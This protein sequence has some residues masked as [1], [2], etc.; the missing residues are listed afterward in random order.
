MAAAVPAGAQ[1][2]TTQPD[3][4]PVPVMPQMVLIA[5]AGLLAVV[6]VGL[7]RRRRM[8]GA[9]ALVFVLGVSLA[10]AW[11]SSVLHAQLTR[12]FT[13]PAGETLPIPVTPVVTRGELQGFQ[14][15]DFENTSGVPLR[16]TGIERPDFDACFPDGLEHVLPA[17]TADSSMACAVDDTL[18]D[19]AACRVNVDTICKAL[20]AQ[21]AATPSSLTFEPGATGVLTVTNDASSQVAAANVTVTPPDGSAIIV[22]ATTCGSSLAPG[23]SCELTLT[24]PTAEGP[25]EI[26]IA[27]DN[28]APVPVMVTVAADASTMLSLST[29]RLALAINSPGGDPLLPG[30]PRV[31]TVTNIGSNPASDVQVSSTGFPAGTAITANTCTGTLPA[32][33]SCMLTIT[34]GAVA[35]P[36][37][38]VNPCTTSP[39]TVPVPTTLTVWADNASPLDADVVVLGYG[40][41]YEGGF[42]F[43]VDDTTPGS[44]SI[45]GKVASLIPADETFRAWAES[46]GVTGAVSLTDGAAN[47]AVLSSA[48]DG[49]YPAAQACLS[50][51]SEGYTDWYLPAICEL[52]RFVGYGLDPGCGT[53]SGNLYT[54]LYLNN[55]GNFR[56][57]LAGLWSST[58]F[59]EHSAWVQALPSGQIGI[60]TTSGVSGVQCVR[61]FAP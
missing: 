36:D 39:G 17:P 55:L 60:G 56:E 30:N 7:L 24:S 50:S 54:T 27:S 49:D 53:T 59:A 15:V 26:A 43:S 29:S 61:A 34:P 35:S 6:T 48:P 20:T 5:L 23:D 57:T 45:G 32:T 10:G 9:F 25:V 11:G 44:G 14:Y 47:S 2:I 3:A 4:L 28:A 19:G 31:I 42:L 40:C 52:S 12:Q 1:S 37:T 58:E 8:S 41:I 22:Q 46:A 16:I 33:A 13:N 18:A 21:L 51:T 38:N